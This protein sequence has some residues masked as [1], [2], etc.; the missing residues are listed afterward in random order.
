M[1]PDV[2]AA[3]VARRQRGT[4][5]ASAVASLQAGTLGYREVRHWPSWFVQRSLYD[6]I[7]PMLAAGMVP[8]E[9]GFRV[10]VREATSGAE[11]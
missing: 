6:C 10:F 11:P 3:M 7:D 9:M 2:Y 5:V 4:A 8:G 1:L